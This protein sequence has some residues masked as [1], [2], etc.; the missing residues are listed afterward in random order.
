MRAQPAGSHFVDGKFVD[1]DGPEF[2]SIHPAD[3]SVIARLRAADAAVVEQAMDAARSGFER[4]SR[5]PPVERGRVLH[6]AADAIR[7]RN[8]ELSVLESLDTGKP[9]AGD[10]RG[11]RCIRRRLHR[12]LRR[13]D[14]GRH[15]AVHR[16]RLLVALHAAR[17]AR[18]SAPASARGTTRCRSRCWKSAPA[19]A[20]RQRDG[21]Q[22]GRSSRR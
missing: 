17:A 12:V 15:R 4:W 10:A 11:R 1:G 18:A 7:E 22:A 3:R 8:R 6:R 16:P 5:T 20:V 14:R 9:I 13:P 19:L 2:E 21:V